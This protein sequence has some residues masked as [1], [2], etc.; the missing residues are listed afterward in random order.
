[1]VALS[2]GEAEDQAALLRVTPLAATLFKYE[3]EPLSFPTRMVNNLQH[4]REKRQTTSDYTLEADTS[5]A[6]NFISSEELQGDNLHSTDLTQLTENSNNI[7]NNGFSGSQLHKGDIAPI[8]YDNLGWF[9]KTVELAMDGSLYVGL[10]LGIMF[11]AGTLLS[12]AIGLF[13]DT[14]L[15]CSFIGYANTVAP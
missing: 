15:I 12:G 4:H 5:E 6:I 8:P 2:C 14:C 11:I 3:A 1:M 13:G 7:R 9:S 10:A